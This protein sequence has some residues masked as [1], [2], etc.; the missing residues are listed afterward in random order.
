MTKKIKIYEGMVRK[1][2]ADGVHL[3][4]DHVVPM[5]KKDI[6]KESSLYYS[7]AGKLINMEYDTVLPSEDE[8]LTY[9]NQVVSRCEPVIMSFLTDSNCSDE[10][11]KILLQF[12][13]SISS[14]VYFQEEEVHPLTEISIDEFKELKKTFNPETKKGHYH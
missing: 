8:A 6:I 9:M 1:L 4:K 10:D 11:R 7:S 14:C 2:F 12:L 13:S 5:V 3:E